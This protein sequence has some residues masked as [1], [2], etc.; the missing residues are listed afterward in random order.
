MPGARQVLR[1]ALT[2]AH[3]VDVFVYVVV[4]NLA[5]EYIPAVIAETFTTSLFT[6]ILLKL[7]LEAVVAVKESIK[8]RFNAATTPVGKIVAGGTLWLL[9]VGSKFVVLEL[10]AYVFRG[11]VSLGGFW[12]VTALILVLLLARSGVR[13][14]LR[15][16]EARESDDAQRTAAS[17]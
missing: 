7:V 2:P 11:S 14:L 1:R 13:R 6:A 5:I 12:S 16:G 9:L 15:D 8:L 17:E 4:L 10:I 3:F